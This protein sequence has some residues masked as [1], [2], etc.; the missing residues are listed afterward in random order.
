MVA[1]SACTLVIH[2]SSCIL[3]APPNSVP[4]FYS[5]VIWASHFDIAP[6]HAARTCIMVTC[7]LLAQVNT[8]FLS[9]AQMWDLLEWQGKHP[10]APV[11]VA[12]KLNYFSELNMKQTIRNILRHHP[13]FFASYQMLDSLKSGDITALDRHY[14]CKVSLARLCCNLRCLALQPAAKFHIAATTV[15]CFI[16][17]CCFESTQRDTLNR[18]ALSCSL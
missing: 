3:P 18:N 13:A 8:D 7:G 4:C 9:S 2:A 14:F 10:Q 17:E 11:A 12:A 15:R 6:T 1:Y 16:L 5:Q